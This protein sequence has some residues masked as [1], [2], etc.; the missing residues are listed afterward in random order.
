MG[1]PRQLESNLRELIGKAD[2]KILFDRSLCVCCYLC[3]IMCS[4]HLSHVIS[5]RKAAINIHKNVIEGRVEI[6]IDNA[7]CDLCA[8]EILPF[9]VKYCPVSA[10]KLE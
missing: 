6:T 8:G 3:A 4:L 1:N 2:K 5:L 10:L 7:R 9:C